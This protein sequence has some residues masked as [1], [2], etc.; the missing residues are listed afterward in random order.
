MA[1]RRLAWQRAL[2]A[3]PQYPADKF[4]GRGVIIVAGGKYLQ[5]AL[6]SIDL[7]RQV[8]SQLR[9]QVW[10][11]GAEEMTEAHRQ[12]LAPYNVETR[13]FR[14]YV[15]ASL[16]QPIASNV[17]MRLFQLK[18]LAILHSDL[19]EVLLLDSDNSALRDPAYLFDDATYQEKGSVFWPDYWQTSRDNPIWDIMGVPAPSEASTDSWEQESGQLL[20][21]KARAWEA[22]N[23]CIHFNQEF[24]MRLL[25]GDKDTFRFAWLAS[26]TSFAMVS[27]LPTSIGTLK[28]LHSSDA[29]GFCG[30][31]MLQHDMNGRPLFVH[32]N[33][34]KQAALP[35]GENFRYAKV[36]G[37]QYS[38][39]RSVPVSGLRLG[40]G[41]LIACNDIAGEGLNGVDQND[42]AVEE[43]GLGDFETRYFA[44]LYKLSA[45]FQQL[46]GDKAAAALLSQTA[47]ADSLQD[48]TD[49]SSSSGISTSRRRRSSNDTVS[50]TCGIGKFELNAATCESIAVC[51]GGE[52]A[53]AMPTSTTDRL[54]ASNSIIY[55]RTY[56]VAVSGSSYQVRVQG[57]GSFVPNGRIQMSYGANYILQ[58]VGVPVS[59]PVEIRTVGNTLFSTGITGNGAFGSAA[60]LVDTSSISASQLLYADSNN[61]LTGGAIDLST[62]TFIRSYSSGTFSNFGFF[63]FSTAYNPD[64]RLFTE[65]SGTSNTDFD[66]L[67]SSCQTS[68]ESQFDCLG[69][70]IYRTSLGSVCYGLSD[71]GGQTDS[72]IDSES[73][74]KIIAAAVFTAV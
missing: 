64:V 13:D 27:T 42:A 14:D 46:A 17:G 25:N 67:R 43:S 1:S 23:L 47:D 10:H 73:Y 63:R 18:P 51:M 16:L 26:N 5:P 28:E 11:M 70:Y 62:A 21:N 57:L 35:L 41:Q 53:T 54:C 4:S 52:T 58:M 74:T 9:I 68:C 29:A 22:L 6:V 36:A 20:I 48:V 50:S 60:I 32:H 45:K 8:H 44:S 33:Q 56:E 3:V 2:A 69:I 55:S 31:T 61:G 72:S 15:N 30:H 12:L 24:Y 39:Y 37:Q 71:L 19:Q 49:S 65:T 40:S 66:N 7:L 38:R 34:L 59:N